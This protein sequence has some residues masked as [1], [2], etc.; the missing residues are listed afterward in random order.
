MT[1]SRLIF[2]RFIPVW[3]LF[4]AASTFS[5]AQQFQA[6]HSYKVGSANSYLAKAVTGDFNGD[7]FQ[8]VAVTT[9]PPS[10]NGSVSVL[11]ANDKGVLSAPVSY[12]TKGSA[13]GIG[14]GDFNQ[15]GKLDLAIVGSLGVNIL[16]GKGDGTFQPAVYYASKYYLTNVVVGDFSGDG[17][18]DLLVAAENQVFFMAGNGDGT[19]QAGTL[20]AS[21]GNTYTGIGAADFNGD[22]K[23]D[24]AVVE[25]SQSGQ[26]LIFLGNGNGTFQSA[27]SYAVGDDPTALA[28]ADFNGD[29]KPDI[30]VSECSVLKNQPDCSISGSI[31]TLLGN[32][33]GTFQPAKTKPNSTDMAA[34]N[35]VAADFNG[36]GKM[37]LAVDCSG[38]SDVSVLLGNGDGT[39]GQPQNWASGSGST[40]VVAG[41]LNGDGVPDLVTLDPNGQNISV[42]LGAKGGKFGAA[43]DYEIRAQ[44][45]FVVAGDFNG[46]GVMDIAS[47]D[48]NTFAVTVML[49]KKGGGFAS[50]IT[51]TI[52]PTAGVFTQD[53]V[54]ADLNGDHNL[55]LVAVGTGGGINEIAVMLGNGDGTFKPGVPY[56]AGNFPYSVVV[57]DFNGDGVPDI[58]VANLGW[59]VYGSVELLIGNGDGTFKPA[60]SVSVGNNYPY[61]IT[62]GD[63]NG[64]GKLDLAVTDGGDPGTIGILLGNGDGTF[65]PLLTG[66]TVG[67]QPY[68][69]AAAD[70]NGDG[71]L[72]IVVC[73]QYVTKDNVQVALGNGDGTFKT[74]T[75]YT[76]GQYDQAFAIADFNGD[77]VPDI[78]L[79]NSGDDASG[80]IILLLGKG[81]GTFKA[82]PTLAAGSVP[83]AIVQAD[84]NGDGKPDLA[85]GNVQGDNITVLLNM[86]P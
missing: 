46:D 6:A 38:G 17:K 5:N 2:S 65:Q 50:P 30:A 19:F 85:I 82:G 79:A 72:D 71:K 40:F 66:P 26:V 4:M 67:T 58:A 60:V 45:L 36:D 51:N 56:A 64:D 15:D 13:I 8:D 63:F 27:A 21:S 14:V 53:V 3:V 80:S 9:Y 41:D 33:D 35:L 76:A 84:F 1:S 75:A 70:L 68:F 18:Q 59:N 55:D 43:H 31:S 81:D 10:G 78:A 24:L 52:N 11:L 37:D 86:T 47:G 83:Y 74:A 61:W 7:G 34:S 29:G 77:G 48:D 54:A 28:I 20:I 39:Y 42:L 32:G 22:G 62:A 49:G 23:L 25:G 73:D 44:P 69:I 12:S 57:G 16:L